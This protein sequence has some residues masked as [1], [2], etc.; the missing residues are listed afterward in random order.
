M[1][2]GQDN[3]GRVLVVEDEVMVAMYVE[4]L[5]SDLGYDTVIV[6]TGLDQAL[7]LARET[8]FDFA[9][10]DINLNGHQS[11]PVADVLRARG[12][13][14]LFASGYGSK[15]VNDNY[16]DA[17]RIQKPFRSRDLAQAI[18]RLRA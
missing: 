9:V 18:D 2:E 13:P 17:V 12:I 6:A 5:L 15:G 10:L 8:A 4:E 14:F 3:F 11:F 16:K 7:S 1:I